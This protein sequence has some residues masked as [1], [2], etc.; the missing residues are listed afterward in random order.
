MK[1]SRGIL[2]LIL[3]AVL[4]AVL[5]FTTVVGW[6]DGKT[7]AAKNIN[8]GLDLEGGVSITYQVKGGTPSAEDMAD[9][10]YKLQ[11]RVE[12]Y[13]TEASV[14]QE[15]D[16][17]ISIEIP[18]VTDANQ[19][20]DELGQPGSLYFISETDSEG[21]R[22]YSMT[23]S[24]GDTAKDF[25]LNKTIEELQEDGSVVLTGT[26]IKSAEAQTYSDQ[27]TNAAK[28][29]VSLELTKEGTEKFAV[30]T[31]EAAG[32]ES[33]GIYYDGAFVSV[34]NVNTE[35]ADGR[36]MIEGSMSFEEAEKLASTIRIGGLTLELEELRS[37]VVGAQLGEA[38][39]ST[40]LT[41]GAIGLA[42]V[43]L[44]MCFVYLLPGFVSSLALLVYIGLVLV[45]LNAFD[46]T[47]T[48]P[49]IAGIILG[50]GMAVDANVIIFARVKE[51][52]SADKSVRTALNAG[53]KKALSAI[54]DGNITTLIA[55]AVLWVLG[56]GSV[57]G[58]A[59]TLALGIVVS[60]FTALVITRVLIY[61]FYAVGLRSQKL[62]GRSLKDREPVN[63]LGKR[64]VFF[65]ISVTLVIA[66]FVFMGVNSARGVGAMNYS[67][68]FKGG[69]S[70]NI[71]FAE[72]YTLEEIDEKIVPVIE[73]TTG[74]NNVQVQKVAGTSQV[75]F[76]TQTLDLEK[77]EAFNKVMIDSFG[78]N[79][80]E[81]TA[82]NISSTVSS[83]MRQDAVVAVIVATI[84]ML[85]YIWFRFKDIRFATSAVLAL[86]HD[87]LI[88][89]GF[90]VIARVSVG[91]TFIAC[92]LTIVG[93][94][95][96]ATIVIF[97][98]IREELRTKTRGEGLDKLVNRC[99][100]K[101]LTRSIYTS[102]TT[103]VM[104]AILFVM[105]VSSIKEF[106]LP[107]MVGIVCGAYSSVCIT[108]A[109]WYVMKTKM[110]KKAVSAK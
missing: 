73:D 103:F 47:L 110:E 29:I 54:V 11:K 78:V 14:Y 97:D 84:C 30:A 89:L 109:L 55:A 67:L 46:V 35:I 69:T 42:I 87:V 22:N 58:F 71:T 18:G 92:M 74:D 25:T 95:I 32:K 52:L 91:N 99:I 60:M 49:G 5:G 15:G 82:E 41:A 50:I 33:I 19:I 24:T 75:I 20:L 26:D 102:L 93:Y 44:F 105:G 70:T 6:G 9:T 8:L 59:Q 72:D 86:V 57:K 10:I 43:C 90:Y 40:S 23:G 28:N 88:V 107:L 100:T 62:Y 104:V 27:T 77:R 96:N 39:I 79:E 106:A 37:N 63:F 61:S 53:F 36:A 4:M 7:G 45:L 80:D 68:E 1:K 16:D 12:Q 3:A 13:S 21:E 17:R 81:I 56:S 66:G 48:L 98:R 83:E 76:K 94:S 2:N 85:L 31:K 38:A 101:T 65:G 34:P 64:K 108:G 51:E